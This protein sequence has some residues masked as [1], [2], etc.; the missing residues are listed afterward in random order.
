MKM[1]TTRIGMVGASV[2][3]AAGCA[4]FQPDGGLGEARRIASDRF[5]AQIERIADDD[6]RRAVDTEVDRL[7]SSTLDADAAVKIALLNAPA[8]QAAFAQLGI[9]E[10]DWVQSGRIR[11]PVL[12]WVRMGSEGGEAGKREAAVLF[13]LWS[14]L[15]MP[16]TREVEARRFDAARMEAAA[17]VSRVAL[18]ARSAWVEAVAARQL[19][20]HL[21]DAVEAAN[22]GRDLSVRMAR[23][24]NWPQSGAF[25]GQ[26][27]FAESVA[28][29]ERAR[30]QTQAARERLIRALGLWGERADRLR[31]AGAP[32]LERLPD[33]LPDVPASIEPIDGLEA[34]AMRERL[35]VAAARA[36]VD[37]TAKS[38]GLTRAT[39]FVSLLEFGP[40]WEKE[41]SGGWHR[42]Y[43]LEL[44]IPLFDWGD[45][46]VAKAESIYRLAAAQAARVAVDARSQVRQAWQGWRTNWEL[47]RHY[48]DEIVPLRERLSREKLLRYNGMLVGVFDLLVDA[49]EKAMTSVAAVS[50]QRDF[51]LA[52]VQMQSAMLGA[53]AP[54]HAASAPAMPAPA[55]AGAAGH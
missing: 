29:L 1:R 7:L 25:R 30:L 11:N 34:R 53:N 40:V 55:A 2:L 23:V 54:A 33:R 10:A 44:S 19:E 51:W 21:T 41:G 36:A 31:A 12:A 16:V 28:Q 48:R 42:G 45:A 46:K 4:Q 49:G 13:D 18:E 3:L 22:I 14:L 47:A 43:E 39:R 20:R 50:A 37:G 17:E 38:L 52:D 15:L 8:L 35:D 26:L 24:G 5:G 32:A 27:A 6:G 9:V